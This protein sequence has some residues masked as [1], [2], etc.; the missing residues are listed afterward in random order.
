VKVICRRGRRNPRYT[1]NGNR[2]LITVLECISA[3]GHLLSPL[4]VTKGAHYYSGNHVRGQGI[5]ESIYTHSSNGWTTNKLG[6]E[7]LKHHYE[8]LTHPKY[9]FLETST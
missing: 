7:W 5:S 6:L 2:E 4:I 3:E 1:C 8:L 9:I